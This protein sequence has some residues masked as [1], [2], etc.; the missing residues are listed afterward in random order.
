MVPPLRPVFAPSPHHTQ[1]Y[2]PKLSPHRRKYHTEKYLPERYTGSTSHGEISH[3]AI[4]KGQK[5][6]L[7]YISNCNTRGK[8]GGKQKANTA[9]Q[10]GQTLLQIANTRIG[11]GAGEL[12]VR[13]GKQNTKQL[14]RNCKKQLRGIA[15]ELPV[16]I[17]AKIRA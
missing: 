1:L 15:P 5:I 7:R 6:T 9:R 3:G 4:G 17:V 8:P 11:A 12:P 10:T 16:P 14:P 2:N 13:G